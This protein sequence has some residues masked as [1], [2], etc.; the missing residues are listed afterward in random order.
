MYPAPAKQAVTVVEPVA[1]PVPE[2]LGQLVHAVSP[3]SAL[4]V[5]SKQIVAAAP[6]GPVY[7]AR[8]TQAVMALEPVGP[9][10][11]LVGQLRKRG[12]RGDRGRGG[13]GEGEGGVESVSNC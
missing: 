13:P 12:I 9:S 1:L 7:P 3:V 10:P 5:F 11:E 4:N 8:A 6:S 2:L